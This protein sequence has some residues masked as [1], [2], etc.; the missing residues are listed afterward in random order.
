MLGVRLSVHARTVFWNRILSL[1]VRGPVVD[2]GFV[3]ALADC[4][5]V[6]GDEKVKPREV[7]AEYI[8]DWLSAYVAADE[9]SARTN[10]TVRVKGFPP[11]DRKADDKI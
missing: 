6:F 4:W 5:L 7:D 2:D 8:L 10:Q 1:V 9:E 3:H 11:K